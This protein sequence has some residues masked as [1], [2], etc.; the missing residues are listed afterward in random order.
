LLAVAGVTVAAVGLR[1]FLASWFE[2]PVV[3][4]WSTVFVS[5]MLQ[6][7][8]FLVLGVALSGA[9]AAFVP[10]DRLTRLL[11]TNRFG[12]VAAG[13]GAGF[14]LPGCECGSVPIS[15]RLVA[16]GAPPGAALA[17]MLAA[18]AI[19]PVVLVSTAV[20]FPGQPSMVAA[21]FLASLAVA[22]VMGMVVVGTD[23]TRLVER[24]RRRSH[25]GARRWDTFTATARHDFLQAGGFLVLGAGAAAAIQT[26]TPPSVL[27]AIGGHGVASVVAMALLAILMSICSEADA[28]VAASFT[29]VSPTA[30]LV[31]LVVGPAVDLKLAAMQVGVFGGRFASWFAPLTA[32]VAVALAGLAGW[33]LL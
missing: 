18:P 28:F 13:G 25:S 21:R 1:P 20:A 9:V 32:I 7:M 8:P 31:F 10:T 6:A 15:G 19:N 30:R 5:T 2:G 17:F 29:Q 26:L 27:A 22:L 11:P 12:A 4:T 24:A 16:A 3:Q 14:L 23:T 33:W